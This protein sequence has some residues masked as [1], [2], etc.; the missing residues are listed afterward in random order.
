MSKEAKQTPSLTFLVFENIG[1]TGAPSRYG[2]PGV[3]VG[4]TSVILMTMFLN[5]SLAQKQQFSFC[6]FDT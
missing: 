2:M 4:M 6:V 1:C 5:S 3:G